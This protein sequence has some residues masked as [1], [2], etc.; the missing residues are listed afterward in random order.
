MKIQFQAEAPIEAPASTRPTIPGVLKLRTRVNGSL[1]NNQ[2]NRDSGIAARTS[3]GS[4][5]KDAIVRSPSEIALVNPVRLHER[6]LEAVFAGFWSEAEEMA[7]HSLAAFGREDGRHSPDVANLSNLLA[8]IAEAQAQYA[9]AEHHA[10]QALDILAVLGSQ[11]CGHEAEVI[12]IEAL[13]RVGTALRGAMRYGEAE[14]WLNRALKLA[15]SEGYGLPAALNNLGVLYQS[16]GNLA[17]AERL[18]RRA[19]TMLPADSANVAARPS[20][21]MRPEL[22][23]AEHG[24][25]RKNGAALADACTYAALIDGLGSYAESEPQYQHAALAFER[26]FGAAHVEAAVIM[27]N[28]AELRWTRGD[29][30]EAEQLYLRATA[31]KERLLGPSHADTALTVHSYASMLAERDAAAERLS[32]DLVGV[33]G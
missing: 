29:D 31:I 7:W 12:R 30:A 11:F 17:E 19:L 26:I 15:E 13:G 14:A 2:T 8:Q 6:A 18:F 20:R 10:R 33:T 23:E 1:L 25:V 21:R 4:A 27:H 24:E 28:L 22:W 9:V 3:R 16:T 32:G 5:A